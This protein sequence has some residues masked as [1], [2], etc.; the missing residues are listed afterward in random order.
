MEAQIVG[1]LGHQRIERGIAGEAENIVGAVVLRPLH[2]LDATVMTVAAPHDA[3]VR[4][5][6]PQA[7]RHVLDDGPHL[8]ALRGARRAQ[9]RGDRC[10]A[11]HMIDVHR[12]KAALVLMRVPERKLLAAMR[13]AERVV[14]VED[15]LLA[16]LHGRAELVKQSR[17]EPRRLGLA[18]RILQTADGRLRGQRLPRSADSARPRPSSTDRAAAGRGRSHPC[19]RRRS[20]RRAPS[21]SRTS[22]AGCGPDRG[23]PASRRQAAGTHRACAP[24]AQQQQAGIGRLVAAVKI[25][26][27]FL[28]ADRWKVEGKRCIVGHGGCGAR[29]IREPKS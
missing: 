20:L 29:L 11:R 17:A 19:A 26:C 24:P 10:A 22:R 18:R 28:A 23:D 16:R 3:G 6:F 4:P 5:M 1:G 9:D 14:D 2:R 15:L 12:R 13:R 27:E 21:P 8:G 25:D 7:L